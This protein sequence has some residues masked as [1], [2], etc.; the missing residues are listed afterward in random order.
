M[1]NTSQIHFSPNFSPKSRCGLYANGGYTPPS[2]VFLQT[3][4]HMLTCGFT[5]HND[6]LC[7]LPYA[8]FSSILPSIQYKSKQ[9]V[10]RRI[11]FEDTCILRVQELMVQMGKFRMYM[12]IECEK[13]I[14]S[15]YILMAQKGCTLE[16]RY[17]TIRYNTNS[18]IT[19]M[20]FGPQ[21]FPNLPFFISLE[22]KYVFET[23]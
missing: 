6:W 7:S 23:C 5:S 18:D 13:R 2:T 4:T 21:F 12:Y 1:G 10:C 3:Q 11:N 8:R 17:N 19:R 15:E 22:R 16:P 20:G 14:N 9:Q